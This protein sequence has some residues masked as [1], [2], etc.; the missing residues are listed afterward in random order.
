MAA[1]PGHKYPR[2]IPVKSLRDITF[3]VP[4]SKYASS[5]RVRFNEGVLVT[6]LLRNG[7]RVIGALGIHKDG[8]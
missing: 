4:M 7:N 8:E 1:I 6:K 2:H 5:V 3:T